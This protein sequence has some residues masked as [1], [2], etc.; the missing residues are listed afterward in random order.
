ME[1]AHACA[2]CVSSPAS[3]R[4]EL[5]DVADLL[6]QVEVEVGDD[7]LVLSAPGLGD[8]LLAAGV[9][10]VGLAVEL[11]DVQGARARRG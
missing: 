10:E 8:D 9:A 2:I 4:V 3:G 11:A 1:S 7:H 6:D 5:P